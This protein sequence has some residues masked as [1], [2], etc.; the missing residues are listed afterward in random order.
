MFV[1]FTPTWGK[2]PILTSIFFNWVGQPPTSYALFLLD[3]T[4][5]GEAWEAQG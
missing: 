1:F 4:S 3:S 5:V 2:I